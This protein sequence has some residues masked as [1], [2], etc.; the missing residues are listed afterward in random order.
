MPPEPADQPLFSYGTLQLASVQQRQFGRLLE[1]SEDHL[2]GYAVVTVQIRDPAVLDASG[3]ETHLALVP[4]PAAPPL[5]GKLFWLT[6]GE[7]A[8]A[9]VYESE[10]YRR[11]WA[12]LASGRAAWIYVKA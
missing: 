4:D 8:A 3:I 11:E 1:G 5:A 12:P 6:R 2:C 10:N 9:D 7:L